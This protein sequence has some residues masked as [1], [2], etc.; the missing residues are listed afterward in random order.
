MN[1]EI[2]G[3]IYSMSGDG[4]T[5]SFFFFWLKHFLNYANPGRS[6][7][8]LHFELEFTKEKDVM[9]W[10]LDMQ[11]IELKLKLPITLVL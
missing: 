6:L 7:L 4:L 9:I 2:P 5:K 3:T 1:G 10:C 8:L 11:S